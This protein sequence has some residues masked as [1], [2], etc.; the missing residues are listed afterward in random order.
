MDILIK[1]A[2][3]IDGTGAPPYCGDV[4][5]TGDTITDIGNISAECATVID[6]TG[7]YVLP[8]FIDTHSHADAGIFNPDWAHQRIVQGI[9]TDI[10]GHCGPSPAPNCTE[11]MDLLR[12]IFFDLTNAG[13]PFPWNFYD[14]AGWLKQVEGVKRSSNYGFLVGHGTLRGYVMGGKPGKASPEE[15]EAMQQLLDESLSQGA[16]GMGLG[17]SMFPGNY[18]DTEELIALAKVVK[19]HDGIIVAHR[20]SE[21][22]TACEAVEEMLTIARATGVRMN[23]AH[24]KATGSDNWGKGRKILKMI[25]DGM[26]EGLDLSLDAYPYI[27]GYTQLFQFFPIEVWGNGEADMLRQFKDPHRRQEIIG[28]LEDGTYK[29]LRE[30][31]GGAA[32]LQIIQCSEHAYDGKTLAQISEMMGVAPAEAAIRMI[33]QYG[34][35]I[36]AFFFLQDT[37]E[38]KDIMRFPHTMVISDGAPSMG[39][40]HPR[41]MGAFSEYLDLFVRQSHDMT[42]EQAVKRMTYMPAQRYRFYDRGQVKVGCKADLIVL[43]WE[44]FENNCTYEHPDGPSKGFDYVLLNGKIAARS[45]K[46]TG[47]GDGVILRGN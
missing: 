25:Q 46:Y 18:S 31:N 32:G 24:V 26:D 36:M 41:Y 47:E 22:D 9:T 40:D 11:Q 28:K 7:K 23:I 4:A 1:H 13:Q 2:T 17:L 34:A 45:G 43:D 38:M 6:A 5:V 33:E 15:L 8:G 12:R 10:T 35:E 21:G 44:H 20:R 16:L 29:G 19:K 14:F 39:H 30:L 3:I 27:A 37:E 42:I